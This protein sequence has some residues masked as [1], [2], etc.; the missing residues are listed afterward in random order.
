MPFNQNCNDSATRNF[1]C[2]LAFSTRLASLLIEMVQHSARREK[3]EPIGGKSEKS[4]ARPSGQV[5]SRERAA[6]SGALTMVAML[7]M[8]ITM[9]PGPTGRPRRGT[10][11]SVELRGPAAGRTGPQSGPRAS[12]RPARKLGEAARRGG[13]SKSWLT[14]LEITQPRRRIDI[15]SKLMINVQPPGRVWRADP[16]TAAI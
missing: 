14:K 9:T 8:T 15:E 10:L 4:V 2:R 1:Q 3:R 16:M 5:A 12:K 13:A 11:H 6:G 7:I